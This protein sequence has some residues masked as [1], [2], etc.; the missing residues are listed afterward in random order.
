MW[1]DFVREQFQLQN[2]GGIQ[3]RGGDV[4]DQPNHG[5]PI[6]VEPV[7]VVAVVAEHENVGVCSESDNEDDDDDLFANVCKIGGERP[8]VDGSADEFV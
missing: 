6:T 3:L 8:R 1:Q 4:L 5:T 7:Q 2:G